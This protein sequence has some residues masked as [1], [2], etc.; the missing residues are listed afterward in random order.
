MTK[1]AGPS[2]ESIVPRTRGD[3]EAADRKGFQRLL[4]GDLAPACY[5]IALGV[6]IQALSFFMVLTALPTTVADIGGARLIAWVSTAFMIA[7]ITAGAAGGLIKQRLGTRRTLTVCVLVFCAGTVLAT[8]APSMPVILAGRVLQGLGEGLIIALAYTLVQELFPKPLVAR[9]MALISLVWSASAVFGPLLSG[10]ILEAFGWRYVFGAALV[11]AIAF[12]A[13]IPFAIPQSLGNRSSGLLPFGRM[14]ILGL[15]ITLIGLTAQGYQAGG[16]AALLTAAFVLFAL[17]ISYDRR[18]NVRLFPRTAFGVSRAVGLGYWMIL[19]MP[20]ASAAFHV[21]VPLMMQH[22]HGFSPMGAGYFATLTTFA[23]TLA[24]LSVSR[25]QNQALIL[26]IIRQG[27]INLAIGC[28]LVW[29]GF[30]YDALI[31][32]ALGLMFS[33]SG[34]GL[35]WAF[36]VQ[37]LARHAEPAEKDQTT[38]LIPVIQSSGYAIGAAVAGLLANLSGL[39]DPVTMPALAR[40]AD[41]VFALPI[42]FSLI[43]LLAGLAFVRS[44][45]RSTTPEVEEALP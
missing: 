12:A 20:L 4:L 43:A 36:M 9:V 40:A 24:A 11:P 37:A 10:L 45:H 27:P 30:S 13:L 5:L 26:R 3:S 31:P 14:A 7:S 19:F 16:I 25:V 28:I 41:A 38:G 42:L 35:S 32:I 8:A 33:G 44:L 34:F 22:L 39:S 17:V 23:W 6:A 29:V 15:G 18:Q 21:F 1:D 2:S